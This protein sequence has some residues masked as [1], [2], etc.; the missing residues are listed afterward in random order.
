M[1]FSGRNWKGPWNIS[2][3]YWQHG[4]VR[5]F[6]LEFKWSRICGKFRKKAV[7]G[8]G[9][10]CGDFWLGHIKYPP[11]TFLTSTPPTSPPHPPSLCIAHKQPPPPLY[12]ITTS[13]HIWANLPMLTARVCCYTRNNVTQVTFPSKHQSPKPVY[14]LSITLT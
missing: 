9:I 12:H 3:S 8:A 5:Y 10:F 14:Q 4:S 13:Q 1:I 2:E 6:K 11:C 7:K